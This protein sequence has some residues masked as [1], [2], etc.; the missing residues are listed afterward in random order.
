MQVTEQPPQQPLMAFD[1]ILSILFMIEE[2]NEVKKS[3]EKKHVKP[4]TNVTHSENSYVMLLLMQLH[5]YTHLASIVYIH[6]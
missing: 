5:V 2:K 4:P 1:M 6:L 3:Q